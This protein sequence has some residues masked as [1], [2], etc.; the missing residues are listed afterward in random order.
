MND[1]ALDWI[2]APDAARLDADLAWL[3]QADHH[4]LRCTDPDFPPQLTEIPQ[5]PAALFVAGNPALLLGAQLAVVGARSA[6][7][8]GAL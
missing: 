8:Q 2:D 3:A 4:L 1:E 5:P 6:S 7:A